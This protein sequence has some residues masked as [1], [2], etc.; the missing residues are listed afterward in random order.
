MT[1]LYQKALSTALYLALVCVVSPNHAHAQ[2]AKPALIPL[3]R[4]MSDKH[5]STDLGATE[6]VAERCAGLYLA[7]FKLLEKD[8][9]PD[10]VSVRNSYSAAEENLIGFAAKMEMTA[11]TTS[12]SQAFQK[13]SAMV[14]ATGNAYIDLIEEDTTYRG[15]FTD[16][17]TIKGDMDICKVF[18]QSLPK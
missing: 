8:T 10:R 15:T 9:A 7:Y 14:V 6:Y 5:L 4:Y 16:D 17:A 2:S 13:V 12:M 18:T 3:S 11:S 1:A